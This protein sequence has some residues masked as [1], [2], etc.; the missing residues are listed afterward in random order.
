MNN[1]RDKVTAEKYEQMKNDL[2]VE[3]YE[4]EMNKAGFYQTGDEISSYHWS[5]KLEDGSVAQF[6]E[7]WALDNFSTLREALASMIEALQYEN[8][9]ESA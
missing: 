1:L 9:G 4:E 8:A 7:A 3:Q 6:S 5:V 2:T